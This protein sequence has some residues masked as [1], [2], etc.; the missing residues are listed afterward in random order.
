M[1]GKGYPKGLKGEKIPISGRI[2]AVADV[3]DAL[4]SK[5]VYKE[6]WKE[7]DVLIY[8]REQSNTQF[9]KDVIDAFMSIYE[10][11]NA[12]RYKYAE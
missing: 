3:Y 4:I 6:S 5:R 2:I 10:T 8:M 9:D 12:I 11:I 1:D 7:D